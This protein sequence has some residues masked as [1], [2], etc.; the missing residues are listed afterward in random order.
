MS[1][2]LAVHKFETLDD[3]YDYLT[4]MTI[5]TLTLDKIEELVLKIESINI[6]IVEL[7]KETHA[8][9]WLKDIENIEKNLKKDLPWDKKK[10]P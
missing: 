10:K 7:A 2:E 6:E 9:L 1:N 8:T 4:K 5:E 3:N